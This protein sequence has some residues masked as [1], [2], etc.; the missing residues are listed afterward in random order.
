MNSAWGKDYIGG[1]LIPDMP[2]NPGV[3][4]TIATGSSGHLDLYRLETQVTLGNG[5]LS[6]SGLGSNAAATEAIKV[7]FDYF[8]AT[9][10]MSDATFKAL[11]MG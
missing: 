5:G 4:H 1:S 3:M 8:K 6:T 10:A 2:L 11:G 7:G 9:A